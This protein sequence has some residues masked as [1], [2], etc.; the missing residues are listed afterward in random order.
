M[1]IGRAW[2]KWEESTVSIAQQESPKEVE[3][4][5]LQDSDT[6]GGIVKR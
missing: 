6:P 3:G 2:D 4:A 5:H 1:S